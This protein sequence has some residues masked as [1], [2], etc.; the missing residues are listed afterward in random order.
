MHRTSL[1][2]E[3]KLVL[4]LP[5]S[6]WI[7]QSNL[8]AGCGHTV[9]RK[10]ENFK[11]RRR[12]PKW[13]PQEGCGQP[14]MTTQHTQGAQGASPPGEGSRCYLN[15]GSDTQET[16]KALLKNSAWKMPFPALTQPCR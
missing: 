1:A 7:P 6:F 16:M 3:N 4:L 5:P 13:K 10:P 15:C 14:A 9:S 12:A 8:E 2:K 11:A